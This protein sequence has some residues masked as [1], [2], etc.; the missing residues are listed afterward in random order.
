[1]LALTATA[2]SVVLYMSNHNNKLH[3]QQIIISLRRGGSSDPRRSSGPQ[4]L[5]IAID[6]DST[7]GGGGVPRHS[8]S[9]SFI[10]VRW[11]SSGKYLEFDLQISAAIRVAVSVYNMFSVMLNR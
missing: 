7:R 1:M 3:E 10:S 8:S 5:A 11:A 2:V 6:V 4:G 9:A